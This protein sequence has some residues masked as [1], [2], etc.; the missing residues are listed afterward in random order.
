MVVYTKDY[1]GICI[2]ISYIGC[3]DNLEFRWHITS[4]DTTKI[5]VMIIISIFVWYTI[6]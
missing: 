1:E 5:I 4:F 2:F 3:E 6:P